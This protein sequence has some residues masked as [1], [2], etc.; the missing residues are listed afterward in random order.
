MKKKCDMVLRLNGFS[1][2]SGVRL[3]SHLHANTAIRV[4][5]V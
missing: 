5:G 2:G 1:V 4:L 3:Q